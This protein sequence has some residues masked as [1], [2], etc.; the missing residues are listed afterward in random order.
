MQADGS[1][2]VNPSCIMLCYPPI[3]AI[4]RPPHWCL[5]A[6]GPSGL[7]LVAVPFLNQ[8]ATPLK[9][10]LNTSVKSVSFICSFPVNLSD[11]L[12]AVVRC[13]LQL[14]IK[15]GTAV[16]CLWGMSLKPHSDVSVQQCEREIPYSQSCVVNI[17]CW[18][19][20][21]CLSCLTSWLK[22]V[23][24]FLVLCCVWQDGRQ[25]SHNC[26]RTEQTILHCPIVQVFL[27]L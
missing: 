11:L 26:L 1:D 2:T 27:F 15:Y 9:A 21:N 25:N 3:N 18:Q 4:C 5:W 8:V 22:A 16:L 17:T 10:T 20:L 23:C 7:G 13:S 6:D 12:S 14:F 24:F 19:T